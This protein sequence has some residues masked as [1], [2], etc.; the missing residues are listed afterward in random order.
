MPSEGLQLYKDGC[1]WAD[2]FGDHTAVV[3][4]EEWVQ[5]ASTPVLS[6]LASFW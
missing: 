4:R 3:S 5:S 2:S 6:R 1:S